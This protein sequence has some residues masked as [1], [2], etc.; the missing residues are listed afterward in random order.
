VKI[1]CPK[2]KGLAELEQDFSLVKCQSCDLEMSYGEYVKYVAHNDITY[3]DILGD[4]TAETAG[5]N[6]GTLDEWD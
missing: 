6:A 4:Y 5:Q 1:R 3:S 2:C